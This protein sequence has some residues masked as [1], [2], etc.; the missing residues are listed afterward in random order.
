MFIEPFLD[1]KLNLATL[2]LRVGGRGGGGGGVKG[3]AYR[4]LGN[5]PNISWGLSEGPPETCRT[6]WY[7][8]IESFK[9]EPS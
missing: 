7:Y 3:S 5:S 1:Q 6:S 4:S 2:L 9:G 8:G